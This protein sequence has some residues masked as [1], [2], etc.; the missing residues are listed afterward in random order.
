[1]ENK[2]TYA[3]LEA[4]PERSSGELIAGELYLSRRPTVRHLVATTRLASVL[5]GPFDRGDEGPGGWLLVS[6]P[7]L[8]MG[9]DALVADLAGWHKDRVSHTPHSAFAMAPDWVCEVL[10]PQT[11]ALD[12]AIKLPLYAR[13]GVKHVWLMDPERMTL[14]AFQLH[15]GRYLLLITHAGMKNVRVE[16]FESLEL[17][18]PYLWG[19]NEWDKK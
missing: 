12:R 7:Q 4:L 16:P 13:A 6:K 11:M 5:L 8:R 19:R 18:L 10:A 1:M 14:E 9:E 2:M 17:E 3:D 15:E